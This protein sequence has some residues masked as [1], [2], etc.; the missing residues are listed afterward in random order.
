MCIRDR[1]SSAPAP[2][3]SE[4]SAAEEASEEVSVESVSEESPQATRAAEET[5]T[6]PMMAAVRLK[7]RFTGY[8]SGA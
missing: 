1:E 8:L 3:D 2:S 7:L 4:P 5:A 6:A